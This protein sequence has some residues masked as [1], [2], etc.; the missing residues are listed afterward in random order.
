[1]RLVKTHLQS[2]IDGHLVVD[3]HNVQYIPEVCGHRL[4]VSIDPV[5]EPGKIVLPAS[6]MEQEQLGSPF[7]TIISIGPECWKDLGNIEVRRAQKGS[8]GDDIVVYKDGQPWAK[9]GDR[10]Y[11]QRFSIARIWDPLKGEMRKDLG[12]IND[13]DVISVLREVKNG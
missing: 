3:V 5:V 9:V 11:I 1:M 4:L 12:F 2:K 8:Y 7:A 10:V 6:V 13:K